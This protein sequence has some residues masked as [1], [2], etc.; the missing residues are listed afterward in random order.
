MFWRDPSC[1]PV[2]IVVQAGAV[3]LRR[4]AEGEP[5][6]EAKP[7]DY[8]AREGAFVSRILHNAGYQVFRLKSGRYD[9]LRDLLMDGDVVERLVIFHY[10]GHANGQSV[11]LVDEN[12]LLTQIRVEGLREQMYKARETLKLIFVNAC[13]TEA[14]DQ[15]FRKNFSHVAFIGSQRELPDEFAFKLAETFYA[16]FGALEKSGDDRGQARTSLEEAWRGTKGHFD[17][18]DGRLIAKGV[19]ARIVDGGFSLA[20]GEGL[21]ADLVIDDRTTRDSKRVGLYC[22]ALIA[23][24]GLFSWLAHVAP[25]TSSPAFQAA[26][27]L[28]PDKETGQA[29]LRAQAASGNGFAPVCE[30]GARD[31]LLS[32]SQPFYGFFVE[33]ARV[34]LLALAFYLAAVVIYARLPKGHSELFS[35]RWK[36]WVVHP[37]HVAF[38]C[39]WAFALPVLIAYHLWTGPGALAE[40]APKGEH[41]WMAARWAFFQCSP[42]LFEGFKGVAPFNGLDLALTAQNNGWMDH[43]ARLYQRPYLAYLPYSGV[44]YLALAIPLMMVISLGILMDAETTRLRLVAMRV[45]MRQSSQTN[46]ADGYAPGF[47]ARLLRENAA[48]RAGIG[49]FA[50]ALALVIAFLLYELFLGRTTTAFMATTITFVA[51]AICGLAVLRLPKLIR[52]YLTQIAA[53][54]DLLIKSAK[55]GESSHLL[56]FQNRPPLFLNVQGAFIAAQIFLLVFC[57]YILFRGSEWTIFTGTLR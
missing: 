49:R 33:W 45:R 37:E 44:V 6:E 31:D 10:C 54:E 50:M 16:R 4:G 52:A 29:V 32:R 34:A 17:A 20:E 51:V 18:I 38:V 22:L 47:Q 25:F 3:G 2:A 43:Y 23:L 36:E 53:L 5:A 12:G 24:A 21:I 42:P 48:L 7:L 40:M 8:L 19:H 56:P 27:S 28:M 11:E 15:E 9:E 55:P 57:L 14:Q 30:P 26:F 46:D 1:R 35:K 41:T 13:L 39:L